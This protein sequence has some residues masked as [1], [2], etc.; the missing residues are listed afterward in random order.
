[1]F[2]LMC[3]SLSKRKKH[4]KMEELIAQLKANGQAHLF[5]A[6]ASKADLERLGQQLLQLHA[7]LAPAGLLGYIKRAQDLL[8]PQAGVD[9]FRGQRPTAARG[10]RL[11]VN[12]PRFE[13]AEEV[14]L[15]EMPWVA[16]VL[17]AG[18]LGE[19]LGYAG[20]KVGLPAQLTT[21]DSFLKMH[22]DWIYAMQHHARVT[23]GDPT[24][25][26]PFLIMTSDDTHDAVMDLLAQDGN[27][28]TLGHLAD[29]TVVKQEKVPALLNRH[30]KLATDPR[31]A[32]QVLCK[33]HGH[34][35]VHGLLHKTGIAARWAKHGV[36]WVVMFQDTNALA[37]R[38]ITAAL[39]ASARGD[40]DVN[41]VAVP[42]KAGEAVGA[43]C[44]IVGADGA[45]R[46]LCVEYN[47]LGPLLEATTGQGDVAADDGHSPFPG[48][49]N[50]L[51]FKCARLAKA[52]A[53]S[54]GLVPEFANPKPGLGGDFATPARL[55]CM[56]QDLPW[57]LPAGAAVAY[58]E[59]DRATCFSPVKNNAHEALVAMRSTGFA[60]SAASCES[61]LYA[62][63]RR[64]LAMAGCSIRTTRLPLRHFLGVPF[65]DGAR[66][67]LAPRFGL[68][69]AQIRAR[70][71]TPERVQISDRSTLVLEGDVFVEQLY[72]DGAL[73][74]SAAPGARIVIKTLRVVNAGGVLEAL[75]QGDADAGPAE[76]MRGFRSRGLESLSIH[77][78]LPG[79]VI[80]AR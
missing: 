47:Q 23:S 62:S 69:V 11:R 56:M 18:G 27:G 17:V 53:Q 30:A 54:G 59:M 71:A 15:R 60:S 6:D 39:G 40:L 74:V 22:C 41:I 77:A 29:V 13:E 20:A 5:P 43:V 33:P 31:D 12:T 4:K 80:I 72:L 55:E 1:V 2:I 44:G 76:R 16:F 34:G 3:R 79:D 36:R 26:L 67:V 78:P 51:V 28:S 25:T 48:G 64:L 65:E 35:D 14:G 45:E 68:T 75:E 70:F 42:R 66:V 7:N 49:I 73:F 57:L 46:T 9:R 52:L 32:F 58:T 37:F 61:D 8:A 24:L 19:R 10:E 38:G 50:V 63:G 21:K